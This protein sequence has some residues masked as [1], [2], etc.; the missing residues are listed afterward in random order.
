MNFGVWRANYC[1]ANAKTY[2]PYLLQE[3]S[4]NQN[5]QYSL[6][7]FLLHIWWVTSDVLETRKLLLLKYTVEDRFKRIKKLIKHVYLLL[8][9]RVEI[10]L[11][12]Y[13]ATYLIAHLFDVTSLGIR[14]CHKWSQSQWWAK[15][16]FHYI[17]T[18][19]RPSLRDSGLKSLW[20]FFSQLQPVTKWDI[21]TSQ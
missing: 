19:R 1:D 6:Q 11:W 2:S 16:T 13:W 14:N 10:T 7:T 12:K 17:M 9:N 20:R 4:L 3:S 15:G 8:K 18:L 21:L 5:T